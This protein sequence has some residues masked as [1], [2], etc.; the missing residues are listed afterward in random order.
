MEIKTYRGRQDNQLMRPTSIH[1]STAGV[2]PTT[3]KKIVLGELPDPRSEQRRHYLLIESINTNSS[4]EH[5][6]E[7]DSDLEDDEE[8]R[9]G[10]LK[11]H[12]AENLGQLQ[13]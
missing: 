10:Q 13:L 12:N 2:P 3:M 5:E 9:S 6:Y 1:F 11:P 7:S 8:E 4:P